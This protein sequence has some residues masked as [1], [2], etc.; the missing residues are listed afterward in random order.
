MLLFA[1]LCLICCLSL[2]IAHVP[3]HLKSLVAGIRLFSVSR[4]AN[5]FYYLNSGLIF[6]CNIFRH[7]YAGLAL[8]KESAKYRRPIG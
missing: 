4:T 2:S 1:S 6:R 7:I 8:K 3:R 5:V